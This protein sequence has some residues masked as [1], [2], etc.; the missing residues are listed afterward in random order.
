MSKTKIENFEKTIKQLKAFCLMPIEND[1]DKAGII[2]AF[3]F[4]FEQSWK[5]LQ[6]KLGDLGINAPSPKQ[7]YSQAMSQNWIEAKDEENW[8]QMIQ[9]RNST[10]HTYKQ[11]LANQ[12]LKRIQDIYLPLFEKLFSKINH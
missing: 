5:S 6:K 10:S 3:E 11:E 1:R 8:L 9:D 7:A 12:I 2:Q 4:T